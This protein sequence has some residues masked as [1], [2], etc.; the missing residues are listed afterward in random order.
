M[1]TITVAPL[2]RFRQQFYDEVLGRRRDALCD[3]LDAALTLDPV[4]SLVGLSL[5]PAFARAWPSTA[6]ALAAGTLDVAAARRLFVRQLPPPVG[7]RELWAI[8]GTT[9][10]RPA[11]KTSPERTFCR[12]VTG[13]QP[14]EGIIAGWEW[15]WLARIAEEQGSW[16]L[17][18]DVARRSP[19]AGKP[20]ALAIAQVRQTLA[21]R[22]AKD[23]RPVVVLDSHYDLVELIQAKLNCDWLVRLSSRRTFFRPPPPYP[24]KGAPRKHGPVFRTH[25]PASHGAPDWSERRPDP[26]RDWVQ[27]DGWDDL[28]SQPAATTTCTVVRVTVGR[29]PRRE[30]PPEPL[31]LAWSGPLPADGFALWHW[32]ERRFTLEHLFR[33]LKQSLGW[34]RVRVR[35]PWAAERWSWLLAAGIWQ[36]WLARGLAVDARL[37]W[38]RAAEPARRSPGRVRRG[39]AG[40]LLACGSPARAPTRRGKSPGRRSGERPGRRQRFPVHRRTPTKA[41]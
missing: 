18:L 40:L 8:D 34:T 32:Y 28:H 10:P 23:P 33:F 22:R 30:T 1:E 41:A 13:G 24:G 31:W 38:Q 19:A 39:F 3:L 29:L 20:T 7:N 11:A 12:F 35:S 5:A 36:L 25:E 21:A 2:T 9:W 16:A 37:P 26:G 14:A 4:T 6:D 17:P 27:V 15:Q